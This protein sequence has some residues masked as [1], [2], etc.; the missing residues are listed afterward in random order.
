MWLRRISHSRRNSTLRLYWWQ[1]PKAR[2]VVSR[3]RSSNLT[4]LRSTSSTERYASHRNLSAGVTTCRS[5]RFLESAE[6]PMVAIMSD[7]GVSSASRSS[8]SSRDS[9]LSEMVFSA[10]S[11]A[12]CAPSSARPMKWRSTTSIEATL[13]C[14]QMMRY[15]TRP[16]LAALP[17]R[18][19]T[20][21]VRNLFI[22]SSIIGCQVRC[23]LD[24]STSCS[25]TSA[26]SFC[27][28]A[29]SSSARRSAFSG[30]W[31]CCMLPLTRLTSP[32]SAA[33]ARPCGTASPRP[34]TGDL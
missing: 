22:T 32:A 12:A 13:T 15:W 5:V 7:S 25:A 20:Q 1:K 33:A 6:P 16:S 14:W 29:Y 2:D 24:D 4:L 11:S 10:R 3:Y 27:P 9:T 8:K 26:G 19:S 31:K 18:I 34:L 21:I 28:T 17:R 30:F 23:R